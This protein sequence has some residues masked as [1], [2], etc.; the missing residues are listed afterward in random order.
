MAG[1]YQINSKM[2]SEAADLISKML[3]VDPTKRISVE[4]AYIH[5][6]ILKCHE[7]DTEINPKLI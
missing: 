4:E 3:I 7:N 5:P 2:S 1:E 6:F